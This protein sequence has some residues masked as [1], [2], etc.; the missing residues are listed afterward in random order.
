[1]PQIGDKAIFVEHAVL[2]KDLDSLMEE[3]VTVLL[4]G[5]LEDETLIAEKAEKFAEKNNLGGL[6]MSGNSLEYEY[7]GRTGRTVELE[8]I[9]CKPA[10][11]NMQEVGAATMDLNQFFKH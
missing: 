8:W 11:G 5:S 7:I 10:W 6:T 9:I 1:M 3:P 4:L 2:C